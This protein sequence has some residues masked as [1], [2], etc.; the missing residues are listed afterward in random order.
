MQY[1]RTEKGFIVKIEKGE[2]VIKT[3]TNFCYE[4]NIKSGVISGIGGANEVTI[5]FF[6][7]DKKEYIP[8]DFSAKNFEILALNGNIAVIEGT[9]F[10]HIHGIFGDSEYK[11]FG[12]HLEKAVI[13]ITAEIVITMT[14]N[15][16]V[17]KLD[18]ESKLNLWELQ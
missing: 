3:I 11:T 13:G 7:M 16:I 5:K 8:K 6:D 18:D 9:P 17:R 15:S 1:K 14:E 4:H 2:E 12:G 10:V